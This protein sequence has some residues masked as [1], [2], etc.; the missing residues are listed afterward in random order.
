MSD[1]LIPSS[2]YLVYLSVYLMGY[3]PK[4][5][6]IFLGYI[7]EKLARHGYTDE[8]LVPPRIPVMV[9]QM[10][11]LAC[12]ISTYSFYEF[13]KGTDK[14][15]KREDMKHLIFIMLYFERFISENLNFF[16]L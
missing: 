9:I 11:D 13:L 10:R 8:G 3:P 6:K 5:F 4:H 12:T 15:M 16:W 7:W 1:T 14:L 2:V